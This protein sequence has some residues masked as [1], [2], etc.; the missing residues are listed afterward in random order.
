MV[1]KKDLIFDVILTGEYVFLVSSDFGVKI[2]ATAILISGKSKERFNIQPVNE[3]RLLLCLLKMAY[4][5]LTILPLSVIAL[6][7]A[8]MVCRL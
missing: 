4:F 7:L 6:P 8:L 1:K 3:H 5:M 2:V